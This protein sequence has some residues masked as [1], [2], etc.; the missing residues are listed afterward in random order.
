V[1]A[2]LFSHCK[3]VWKSLYGLGVQGFGVLF[4]LSGFLLSVDP[5]GKYSVWSAEGLPSKFGASGQ[6]AIVGS[7]L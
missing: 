7:L 4:L 6:Q 3:V 1:E 2:F 5:G